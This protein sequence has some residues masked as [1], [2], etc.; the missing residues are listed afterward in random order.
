MGSR[1][2]R[3]LKEWGVKPTLQLCPKKCD[4]PHVFG[5]VIVYANVSITEESDQNL[6]YPSIGAC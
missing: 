5:I 6:E 4:Q 3:I 1:N 2:S